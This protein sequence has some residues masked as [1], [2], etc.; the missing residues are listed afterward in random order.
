MA[1]VASL[2]AA[3]MASLA[4]GLI[5]STTAQARSWHLVGSASLGAGQT[6]RSEEE[7]RTTFWV[8]I[9]RPLSVATSQAGGALVAWPTVG[10]ISA[11]QRQTT[12]DGWEPT[13]SLRSPGP[14]GDVTLDTRTVLGPSGAAAV[15]WLTKT[16]V[17]GQLVSSI[18][19]VAY[20]PGPNS[21]WQTPISLGSDVDGP[22][23]LAFDRRGDLIATWLRWEGPYSSG[24]ANTVQASF[25][26]AGKGTW[27]PPVTISPPDRSAEDAS[28]TV[29]GAGN[30]VA[31]WFSLPREDPLVLPPTVEYATRPARTGGWSNP[32]SLG[33][34]T[35]PI[36]AMG[37]DGEARVLWDGWSGYTSPPVRKQKP[38]Y[39]AGVSA[40]SAQSSRAHALEGT[41]SKL[42]WYGLTISHRG[43]VAVGWDSGFGLLGPN[44][45]RLQVM[46]LQ[47]HARRWSRVTLARWTGIQPAPLSPLCGSTE[48]ILAFDRAENL[49]AVWR[50]KCS[51]WFVARR[52]VHKQTWSRSGDL[53]RI[54]GGRVAPAFSLTPAGDIIAPWLEPNVTQLPSTAE[55]YLQQATTTVRAADLAP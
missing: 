21:P 50:E 52:A 49:S 6:F 42:D 45:R 14:E 34:G 24:G 55:P 25:L 23:A 12:H 5:G 16:S 48:P 28:V 22:P 30:A 10:G 47:S 32:L 11:S 2:L 53:G 27:Q 1:Q 4:V 37:R 38:L 20:R 54:T 19:E 41:A 15:G 51:S 9:P 26:P 46:T 3:A 35:G 29:D 8:P 13:S 39:L 44:G 36:V 31:V 17:G 7:D 40:L 43:A 33:V 18:A